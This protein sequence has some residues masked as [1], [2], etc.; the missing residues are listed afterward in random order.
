MGFDRCVFDASVAM[1]LLLPDEDRH[2]AARLIALSAGD[3]GFVVPRHWW[4]EVG[5]GLLMANRRGR[6]TLERMP[7]A[8]SLIAALPI[9]CDAPD[10]AAYP[11]AEPLSLA[12][13]TGLTLYDAVYLEAAQRLVLPLA[14]F[15]SALRRAAVGRSV[16]VLP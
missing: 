11:F 9:V 5:N 2:D 1:A 16:R 12:V 4:T 8:L 3:A 13:A 6:L 7:E 15:D 14:T 10:D